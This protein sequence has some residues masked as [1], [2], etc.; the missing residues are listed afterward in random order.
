LRIDVRRDD[1]G[2]FLAS[3]PE[4][5]C[6]RASGDTEA[7]ALRNVKCIALQVLADMVDCGEDVPVQLEYLFGQ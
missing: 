7:A 6:V 3:I 4:L 2:R 1:E 5:G